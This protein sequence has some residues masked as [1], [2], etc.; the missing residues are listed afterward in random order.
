MRSPSSNT[1]KLFVFCC[2]G[3]NPADKSK[4]SPFCAF[5]A[6]SMK[7]G[8]KFNRRLSPPQRF[9]G[10]FQG[11]CGRES[12]SNEYVGGSGKRKASARGSLGFISLPMIPRALYFLSLS[13]FLKASAEER[14]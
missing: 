2:Y 6:K 1:I 14:S 13:L 12:E 8:R 10:V 7:L 11:G 9:L 3:D 5:D 4:I